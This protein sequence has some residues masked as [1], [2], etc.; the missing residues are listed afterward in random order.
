MAEHL[1]ERRCMS[2]QEGHGWVG[3][4]ACSCG[5]TLEVG[6]YGARSVVTETMAS[7]WAGHSDAGEATA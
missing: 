3:S 7:A 6:P 5:W 2:R 1:V 4:L